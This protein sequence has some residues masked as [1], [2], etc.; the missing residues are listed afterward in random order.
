VSTEGHAVGEERIDTGTSLLLAAKAD[1][2]GILTINRPD[3]R[4]ALAG[5]MFGGF[6]SALQRFA[7]DPD[8][9]CILLTGAGDAF[10]AGGDTKEFRQAGQERRR[11]FQERYDELL[12]HT[13]I[14]R[15][16]HENP[17][18]SV[19]ALPG[20]AVGAGLGLALACDLRI[21]ALGARLITGWSKLGLSGDYGVTWF[22]TRLLGPSR[23]LELMMRSEPVDAAAA[24]RLGLV[25]RVVADAGLRAE[26]MAWARE[27]AAGPTLAWRYL[28]VNIRAAM[29]HDLAGALPIETENLV[30]CTFTHQHREALLAVRE[31]RP[32]SFR[33]AGA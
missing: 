23:A 18:V 26:A 8:V 6:R 15:L 1:G 14:S 16:L 25:N 19:A 11:T 2:V 22:L 20:P 12:A 27:I 4:N 33:S 17:K 10:C 13:E 9:G 3:R 24:E 28:K 7:A 29:R 21:A 30:H 31:G 5:P 32:P